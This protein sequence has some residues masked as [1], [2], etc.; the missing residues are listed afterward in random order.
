M[1]AGMMQL[2]P[3]GNKVNILVLSAGLALVE[4]LNR[5]NLACLVISLLVELSKKLDRLSDATKC[6]QF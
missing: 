4:M 2:I 6:V 1:S 5:T 3:H